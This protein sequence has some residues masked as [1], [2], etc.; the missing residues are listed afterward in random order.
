MNLSLF[1]KVKVIKQAALSKMIYVANLLKVPDEITK[2]VNKIFFEYLWKSKSE[3]M[4]RQVTY[5]SPEKGGLGMVNLEYFL[6]ALKA[7]WVPRLMQADAKWID[8]FEHYC[9]IIG[10]ERKNIRSVAQGKS[11]HDP[12]P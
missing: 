9:A 8:T 12:W 2:Q 1:G 3:R 10:F 4:R 5:L 11:K 6:K 7:S